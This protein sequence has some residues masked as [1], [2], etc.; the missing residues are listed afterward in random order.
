MLL[1][2]GLGHQSNHDATRYVTHHYSDQ[3]EGTRYIGSAYPVFD[4]TCLAL[5]YLVSSARLERDSYANMWRLV[6]EDSLAR[7]YPMYR[8]IHPGVRYPVTRSAFGFLGNTSGLLPILHFRLR[9][10]PRNELKGLYLMIGIFGSHIGQRCTLSKKLDMDY[11]TPSIQVFGLPTLLSRW[12]HIPTYLT[13]IK[14]IVVTPRTL[15][16]RFQDAMLLA[17]NFVE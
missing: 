5:Y 17:S 16:P 9:R 10:L 7:F 11:G 2:N 8:G 12:L 14:I 1:L 6:S 15:A 4:S 3:L 13:N